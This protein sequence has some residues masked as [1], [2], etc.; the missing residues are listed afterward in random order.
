MLWKNQRDNATF[1]TIGTWE[2]FNK[3]LADAR[4]RKKKQLEELSRIRKRN[5]LI[6]ACI[7]GA[8]ALD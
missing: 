5:E 6:V 4:V 2:A 7:I 8:V 3:E 1:R